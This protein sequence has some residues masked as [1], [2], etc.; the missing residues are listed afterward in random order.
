MSIEEGKQYI[1][2]TK[3]SVFCYQQDKQEKIDL[4]NVHLT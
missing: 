1:K 4:R 2:N 3:N